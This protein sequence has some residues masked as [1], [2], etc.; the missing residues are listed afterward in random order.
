MRPVTFP[1]GR[2]ALRSV[3]SGCFWILPN[4]KS[5]QNWS[6]QGTITFTIKEEKSSSCSCAK[7]RFTVEDNGMGM[8]AD[9]LE[10]ILS[11]LP[12]RKIP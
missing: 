10:R 6:R 2:T 5:M 11:R 8:K 3:F 12:D 4:R 7:Y 1:E 9:Y